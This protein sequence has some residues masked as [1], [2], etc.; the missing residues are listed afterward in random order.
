M[1]KYYS[2]IGI[3]QAIKQQ[4][5]D[6]I[7]ANNKFNNMKDLD[8][9]ESETTEAETLEHC[10]TVIQ[11]NLD[12]GDFKPAYGYLSSYISSLLSQ[13]RKEVLEELKEKL[14]K[15]KFEASEDAAEEFMTIGYNQCLSEIKSLINKQ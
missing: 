1:R 13:Q 5:E 8:L 6:N 3:D 15:V 14:P 11:G 7:K 9:Q 4:E 10:L 2:T 12:T